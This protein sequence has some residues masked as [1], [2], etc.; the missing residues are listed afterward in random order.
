MLGSC[1]VQAQTD[2][3]LE[4]GLEGVDGSVY[5]Y[6][7]DTA[8]QMYFFLQFLNMDCQS[9]VAALLHVG[10]TFAAFPCLKFRYIPC[11]EAKGVLRC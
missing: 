8:E 2:A 4:M 3:E 6:V 11:D 7:R 1:V 10:S 5:V 9:R